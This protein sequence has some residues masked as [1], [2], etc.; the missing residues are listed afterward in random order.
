MQRVDEQRQIGRAQR[1][2]SVAIAA[3][4]L[5]WAAAS[6]SVTS[7]FRLQH[8]GED[9]AEKRRADS[10]AD[11]SEQRRAGGRDAKLLVGDGVLHGHHQ[12]LHDHAEA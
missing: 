2:G 10:A 6:G 3:G 7:M 8:V 11:G 12:D 1:L 4:S 5:S 9:A